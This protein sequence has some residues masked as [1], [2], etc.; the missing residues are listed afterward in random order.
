MPGYRQS[1]FFAKKGWSI[2]T[3]VRW[4]ICS[5]VT[6]KSHRREVINLLRRRLVK[7]SALSTRNNLIHSYNFDTIPSKYD[8]LIAFYNS[9]NDRMLKYDLAFLYAE[10]NDSIDAYNTLDSISIVYD[11]SSLQQTIHQDYTDYFNLFLSGENNTIAGYEPD[12][13]QISGLYLLANSSSIPVSSYAR[14]ILCV[15]DTMIYY[16]PI[17]LPDMGYKSARNEISQKLDT[18]NEC[19]LKIYP[20]PAGNFFIVEYVVSEPSFPASL[21]LTDLK[22][23]KI[24]EIPLF[25]THNK[26]V[27]NTRNINPGV[28]FCNLVEN[29]I[30]KELKKIVI[31][32]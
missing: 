23:I 15:Y 29:N 32:H 31:F 8:S 3:G 25:Q 18:E 11:L 10:E 16:E 21:I 30:I 27:I 19:F 5:G 12:S 4:S 28:Y 7:S 22:G 24:K 14:S 13:S 2:S 20:N 26:I 17:I 9:E 1:D 6:C